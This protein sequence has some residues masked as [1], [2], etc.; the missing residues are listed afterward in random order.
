MVKTCYEATNGE[1]RSEF[2]SDG[3]LLINALLALGKV[4]GHMTESVSRKETCFSWV[5][6]SMSPAEKL[7]SQSCWT[8]EGRG[9]SKVMQGDINHW[10]YLNGAYS[11]CVS[12][13]FLNLRKSMANVWV[14]PLSFTESRQDSLFDATWRKRSGEFVVHGVVV[15][16]LI[17]FIQFTTEYRLA[18][19]EFNFAFSLN[20]S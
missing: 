19:H 3:L 11:H 7:Q 9:R 5:S 2:V 17:S 8:R 16:Y 13:F 14:I 18:C 1:G 6:G 10:C 20:K 15:C 4:P 12:P